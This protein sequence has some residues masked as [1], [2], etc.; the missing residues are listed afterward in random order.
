MFQLLKMRKEQFFVTVFLITILVIVFLIAPFTDTVNGFIK[1]LVSPSVLITDY[2]FI[3]GLSATLLNVLLTTFMNLFIVY[4]LG[5]KMTGPIFACLLT[6]AGFAFFGKNL[7][8]AIPLYIG[9]YLYAKVSKTEFKN[10][11]I[12]MLL[13]S[14]IS[15]IVSYLIFGLDI[16]LL[17]SIPIGVFTG[18]FI[19]FLLPAFNAHALRFHQGYNL[20]NT[21]FSMGVISM[22][23]TGALTSFNQVIPRSIEVN[24]DYHFPLLISTIIVSLLFIAYAIISDKEVFKKYRNL[25]KSSGRLVTDFVR[26][27]GKEVVALNIGILGLLVSVVIIVT[28]VLVNGAVMGAILTILGFAAFGK[29]IKNVIPVMLGAGLAIILTPIEFTIGPILALFFVTGLAPLAGKYGFFAGIIAGFIH[30]LI[31]S[32]ALNFQGGFDLY[33]NGFAAG[34]VAA[35]LSPIFNTFNELRGVITDEKN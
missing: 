21:G 5:L 18:I 23:L 33:N 12:V 30:L 26:D 32:L 16:D 11:I 3:A 29:H 9:I 6:I 15:P 27:H 25:I 22:M 13:S 19:G 10:H 14:G 24:N 1:I 31:V 2:I 35:V 7:F 28:G 34:F 17:L 20:Y 4:K 8:N